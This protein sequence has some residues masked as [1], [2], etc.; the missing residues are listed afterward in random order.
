MP[1]LAV[2]VQASHP[3][4]RT[5]VADVLKR[6]DVTAV[7]TAQQADVNVLLDFPL[8]WAMY[9]LEPIGSVARAQTLVVTQGANP[10]C[11]ARPDVG[12][13]ARRQPC[14]P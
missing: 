8:S 1:P 12:G 13:H 7:P 11:G 5:L 14:L 9:E 3:S 6:P 2:N 10:E 4:F